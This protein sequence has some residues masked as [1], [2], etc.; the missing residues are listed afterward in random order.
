MT[1]WPSG[2]GNG[3]QT[4]LSEF[5][6]HI[7]LKVQVS[8]GKLVKVVTTSAWN[9]EDAG[10]IPGLSTNPRSSSGRTLGFEPN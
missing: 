3:L 7:G 2:K 1:Y 9:T 10:S 4:R 5:D 8:K 6:S